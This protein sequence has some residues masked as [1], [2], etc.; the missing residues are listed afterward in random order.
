MITEHPLSAPCHGT[1]LRDDC[2]SA[3]ACLQFIRCALYRLASRRGHPP[4]DFPLI[5]IVAFIL[6]LIVERP[7]PFQGPTAPLGGPPAP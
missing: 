1:R 3:W 7:S 4:L 5:I 6:A 2:A